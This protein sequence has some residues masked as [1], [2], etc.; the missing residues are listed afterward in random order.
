MNLVDLALWWGL[1]CLGL[2]L[3]GDGSVLIALSAVLAALTTAFASAAAVNGYL[4]RNEKL[5]RFL[6]VVLVQELLRLPLVLYS[7]ANN[8]VVW[9]GRRFHVHPDGMASIVGTGSVGHRSA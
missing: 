1:A 2:A 5:W 4:A 6:W 9:R 3:I 7:L 8:D